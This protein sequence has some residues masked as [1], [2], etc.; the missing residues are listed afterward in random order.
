VS[1][2]PHPIPGAINIAIAGLQVLALAA[3]LHAAAQASFFWCAL[4]LA[5]AYGIIMNSVY[6]LI[7]EAEHDV[8]HP[9]PR[10]NIAAGVVL[11]LFFPAPFHLVRQG[12]L[13]HHFRNRSDDEAFDF[14]FAGDP[15]LWKWTQF[16]GILTGFYWLT[17][18]VGNVVVLLTPA[19]LRAD[20]IG[21]DRPTAALFA[22][23]NPRYVRLIRGEAAA[24]LALHAGLVWLLEIP[25]AHYAVVVYGFGLSW[26]G[27]QY[28][29]HFATVRDA[30]WGARNLRTWRW[31]DA[32]W[33][34]HNYHLNHH[35]SPTVPWIHLPSLYR[36]AAYERESMGLAWL[37]M[38]RGP[39]LT[40]TRVENRHAGLVIR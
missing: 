37:R 6:S 36:G 40:T 17:V 39:R 14:Y 25:L 1:A 7:H 5:P 33:L 3:T 4:L 22:S 9:H 12:H 32:V 19:L 34:N 8:F 16:Y 30:R 2:R 20:R 13:G 38:W 10:V 28:V 35:L 23:L 29:H 11:A 26:S 18:A 21:F 15:R 31:L 27:L 24:A